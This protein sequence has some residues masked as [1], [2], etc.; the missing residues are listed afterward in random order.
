MSSY[1][2]VADTSAL[3]PH[4]RWSIGFNHPHLLGRFQLHAGS[5][6]SGIAKSCDQIFNSIG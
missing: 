3:A 5:D 6:P 2:R 1:C 4:Q